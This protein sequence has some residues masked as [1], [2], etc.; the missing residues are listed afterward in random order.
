MTSSTATTGPR[1]LADDLRSRDD[2]SLAEL[3]RL[4]PDLA[5]PPPGDFSQLAGRSV[6]AASTSRALD[7]L[8]RFTLQVLEACVVV[9]EPFGASDVVSLFPD[10]AAAEVAAQV[11]E[12]VARALVWGPDDQWRPTATV[13]EVVGRFPAGLGP[14][15]AQLGG[16]DL[17]ALVTQIGL[18]P[19]E[20]LEVLQTLTWTTPTGRVNDADR[21]ITPE[22]SRTPVEWLLAH[23]ILRTL[24]RSTVVLPREIGLA[25]R[26][27]RLHR[28]TSPEPPDAELH[29]HDPLVVD[30]L[31]SGTAE[32]LVRLTAAL[33]DR[34]AVD[35]PGVLRSGGL[36]VRDLRA[37]AT[38]LDVDEQAAALVIETARAAG[39]LATSGETEDAWLPTP[40]YDVWRTQGVARRWVQLARAWMTTPG[41]A[42]LVGTST[43]TEGRVN[44]LTP[45]GERITAPDIRQWVLD[46]IS[47]LPDGTAAS[48]DSVVHRH[49]WR[50][51]R[52][53]G[54]LRDDLVRWTVGEA[55][56]IGIC[57]RGAAS[58]TGR[59][60]VAGDDVAAEERLA[61]LLPDPVDHVLLQADLTAVAP[62]PL[63]DELG[64]ALAVM[65]DVESSGGATVFRFTEASV[66]RALDAGR[67]A[68]ECHAFL[69][70]ISATPVP[71]PLTYLVDDVARRHGRLRVGSA[72][73]YIRSEDPAMLDELMAGR[74]AESLRLRRLAPTVAV[75][76][77][78]PDLL[79]ER[80]RAL[81]L[82]PAAEAGD[83]SVVVTRPDERR[84][85]P[86]ATPHPMVS[87]PPPPSGTVAAAIVRSLR[88]AERGARRGPAT[89]GPAL[90]VGVPRTAM[91]ETL[92][93]L[94]AAVAEG[95][96]LWLGYVDN[97]GVTG[98]RV[99]DPVAVSGGQ[100]TAYDH[101]T[102][103]V[104]Q[105]AVHRVTGVA[106][107]TSDP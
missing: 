21:S 65:A 19:A 61:S 40:A 15:L 83:G 92:E 18:A 48:I 53:G 49:E 39:L 87:D 107:L 79:L 88:A 104:R 69:T 71:Q 13:R 72:S 51:P 12:L 76:P 28:E 31:A 22:A 33:L 103:S 44:A 99:V 90:G 34:W 35:P 66:R 56:A 4:R 30:R 14:S 106:P 96:S 84:T 77:T 52:R 24:D 26:G 10:V 60:L 29:H 101:R 59:L 46:D 50:R 89:M 105:F 2:G 54:R 64:R 45:E 95:G 43:G 37:A 98:E 58:S 7:H 17:D 100:L 86:R 9:D 78:P 70:S 94:K 32:Q 97:D 8:T 62:G 47:A 75:S 20:A 1:S 57:A 81:G 80:L 11:Q 42:S 6:T 93:V 36:G 27:G 55:N 85:G 63:D 41:V 102:D 23:R 91:T 67:S 38:A 74:A 3:L 25:L 73:A 82:A 16:G 68:A 5:A